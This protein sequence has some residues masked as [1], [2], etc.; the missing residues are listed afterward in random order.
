[1]TITKVLYFKNGVITI[2][3][4]QHKM[5]STIA[6]LTSNATHFSMYKSHKM[7]AII[8]IIVK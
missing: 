2:K 7:L 3:T 1:M 8:T 5:I 6:R 4:T